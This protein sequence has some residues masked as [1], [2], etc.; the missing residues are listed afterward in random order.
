MSRALEGVKT[1]TAGFQQFLEAHTIIDA[2]VEQTPIGAWVWVLYSSDGAIYRNPV[3]FGTKEE[4]EESLD[5]LN[6]F[7]S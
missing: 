6:I 4:A 2:C 5:D 3:G 7:E 1:M